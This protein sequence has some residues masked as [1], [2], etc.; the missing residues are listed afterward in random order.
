[1]MTMDRGDAKMKKRNSVLLLVLFCLVGSFI[2]F[3]ATNLLFS[4][5]S[6]MFYGVHDIYIIS[7]IPLFI[8]AVDFV[9]AFIFVMRYTRYPEY[10]RAMIN[11]YT[12]YLA[13]LS[14]V[15]VVFSILTGTIIYHSFTAPYPFSCYGLLMLIVHALLLVFAVTANLRAR[16]KLP[17]DAQRKHFKLKYILYSIVLVFLTYFTFSKFGALLYAP[18]YVHL[19]TLYMTFPFYV[20]LI[21]PLLLLA[22]VVLYFLDWYVGREKTELIHIIVIF[23]LNLIFGIAIFIIGYYNTG[24]ISAISPALA[25]ER[26]ATYPV[27][28][29]FQFAAM[30]ILSLYYMI[31]AIITY[32][33]SKTLKSS[34]KSFRL[35]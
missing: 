13:L 22:H 19:R 29:V 26:L 24:F 1:M 21:L 32:R 5:L 20:S 34:T 33:K 11:L 18:V 35:C 12:I 30:F 6:N 10:K 8:I 27:N 28:T 4:D 17:K 3:Y 15:G 16:R 25:L 23:V 7:S 2:N 31:Y 9:A 14:V